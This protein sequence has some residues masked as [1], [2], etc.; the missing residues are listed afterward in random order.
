MSPRIGIVEGLC[1]HLKAAPAW[2]WWGVVLGVAMVIIAFPLSIFY[3]N[4]IKKAK[5]H[6]FTIGHRCLVLHTKTML[7]DLRPVYA[8]VM[9]TIMTG[10]L[11]VIAH[12]GSGQALAQFLDRY[13]ELSSFVSVLVVGFIALCF[14]IYGFL[15][16][17]IMKT[18][19]EDDRQE[20]NGQQ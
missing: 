7:T 3:E 9:A 10:F 13:G 19:P 12:K 20:G 6:Q 5:N 16:F 4:L 11:A 2:F 18:Q 14:I 8:G 15:L 1:Q 17:Y